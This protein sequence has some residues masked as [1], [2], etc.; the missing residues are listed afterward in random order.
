MM[1][2]GGSY[3]RSE[4]GKLTGFH[5]SAYME[6]DYPTR[7]YEHDYSTD[8][9]VNEQ[10]TD[11]DGPGKDKTASAAVHQ[12]PWAMDYKYA[13]GGDAVVMPGIRDP[14][15]SKDS[16]TEGTD[17]GDLKEAVY[18]KNGGDSQG[19]RPPTKGIWAP[20]VVDPGFDPIYPASQMPTTAMVLLSGPWLA[21]PGTCGG[22]GPCPP[23]QKRF[24]DSYTGRNWNLRYRE[25]A[26]LDT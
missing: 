21:E 13:K 4:Y 10:S 22:G 2:P 25:G 18:G 9:T 11:L 14:K 12:F 1:L 16:P 19:W 6:P 7:R 26:E 24:E 3:H 8:R 5:K 20:N 15:F 23:G 17:G